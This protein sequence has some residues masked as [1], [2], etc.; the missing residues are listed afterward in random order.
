[1]PDYNYRGIDRAGKRINGIITVPDITALESELAE[2][3]SVLIE[4]E[5]SKE[6][7]S[8]NTNISIFNRGPKD[9]ELIDF[10]ITLSSLLKAGI[11][12]IDALKA[13]K[14]E[15]ETPVFRN[16][17]G[18]MMSSVE[19]GKPFSDSL[20]NH[21]KVFSNHIIGLVRA[22]EFGGK[23]QDTL[24]ELVRYLEWQTA[25]KANIKQATRYPVTILVALTGLILLLFTF[26]VPKFTELLISL[27]VPLPLPTR[28]VMSISEFFVSK[29]WI[30]ML[31]GIITPFVF[32]Y[33]RRHWSGFVL[34]IDTVKLNIVVFGELNRILIVSKFVYNFSTLLEA[35]VPV[36]RSLELCERVVGNKVMENALEE[37]RSDVA[38]GMFLNES[39][40][41]HEIFPKRTLLMI[42]VGETS[43]DIGGALKNIANYYTEEIPRKIKK[44]FGIMEPI[45]M[46]TLIGVVGFTAAAVVLPIL[47]LFGAVK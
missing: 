8:G 13:I 7:E 20:A 17:I 45:V 28:M 16:I 40:R 47:S 25:L 23:L 21:P 31:V 42:T 14:D 2:S 34:F 38:G 24:E 43:G 41:K 11:T 4:A 12:F 22:G 36:L 3:G 39:L 15:V 44:V 26:V 5:D 9:R 19:E 27:H 18:D 37:A 30:L 1:M 35:G 33:A 10:F 29:W 32:R 6:K 46:F